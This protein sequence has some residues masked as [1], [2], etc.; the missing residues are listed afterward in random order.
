[1]LTEFIWLKSWT[2]GGLL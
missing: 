2:S 1:M